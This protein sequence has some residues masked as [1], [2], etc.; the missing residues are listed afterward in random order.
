MSD[1]QPP[2]TD[3]EWREFWLRMNGLQP[4][5]YREAHEW[6]TQANAMWREI[7]SRM[8]ID[9]AIMSDFYKR[10]EAIRRQYGNLDKPPRR[11]RVAWSKRKRKRARRR[12]TERP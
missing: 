4:D 12:V 11:S 2:A 1:M 5:A 8:Q 9:M 7:V 6:L 10:L 3:D